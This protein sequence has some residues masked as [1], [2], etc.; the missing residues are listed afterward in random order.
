M[1]KRKKAD[2]YVAQVQALVVAGPEDPQELYL[3][4]RQVRVWQSEG[5]LQGDLHD[6]AKLHWAL[7]KVGFKGSLQIHDFKTWQQSVQ[8]SSSRRWTYTVVPKQN[9]TDKFV[10][11]WAPYIVPLE[12]L[13]K[14]W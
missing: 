2:E 1:A 4:T 14:L 3:S 7:N 10:K 8:Q 12:K 13:P 5:K 9:L 11:K 6:N